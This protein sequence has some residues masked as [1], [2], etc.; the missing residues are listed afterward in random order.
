MAEKLPTRV[1]LV[2]A[3]DDRE[4]VIHAAQGGA[5]AL[6]AKD[7]RPEDLIQI[8]RRVMKG[9]YIFGGKEYDRV[10]LERWLI[11][12]REGDMRLYGEPDEIYYPLSGREM[13]VL[14]YLTKGLSNKE[15][16]VALGISH[17]TIKNHVTSILRKLGVEDRTQAAVYALRKG[18]VRIES[19]GS[20]AQEQ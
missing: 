2:T 17:Q 4:Q 15:I 14:N 12:M 18:W 20:Q 1:V 8:I 6:C 3:Y 10:G 16:A 11:A 7:V 13:E 9:K 19:K 5:S